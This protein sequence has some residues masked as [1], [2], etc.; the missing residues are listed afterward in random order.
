MTNKIPSY[1]EPSTRWWWIRHAPVTS[2]NGCMYGASDPQ[3]EITTPEVYDGLARLLPGN[4]VCVT[5]ALQRTQQTLDEIFSHGLCAEERYVEAALSEQNFGVWQGQ[6]YERIPEL[7]SPK[8]HKHWFTT[9]DNT[10]PDGESFVA[11]TKRVVAVIEKFNKQHKGR[12]IIAVAHG[13]PIRAALGHALGLPP[14]DC[15]AFET[16]NLSITRLDYEPS[17]LPGLDWYVKYIN[18]VPRRF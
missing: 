18:L 3:A 15:L 2:N 6:P 7:A 5:S 1:T 14:S 13:G 17:S 9:A 12:D 10:P 11:L 4:S 16:S 8:L